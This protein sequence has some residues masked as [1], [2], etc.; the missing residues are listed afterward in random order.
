MD[1]NDFYEQT[2][3]MLQDIDRTITSYGI[4]SEL[5]GHEA[6]KLWLEVSKLHRRLGDIKNK[7][8]ANDP[9]FCDNG[10]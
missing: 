1:K 3:G 8:Q 7:A 9:A 2:I 4:E 6:T 5:T 10:E